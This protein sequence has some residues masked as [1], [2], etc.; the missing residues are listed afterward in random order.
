MEQAS[1]G[2]GGCAREANHLVPG[3]R[4]MLRQGHPNKATGAHDQKT[5]APLLPRRMDVVSGP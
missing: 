3:A 2:L 5:H 1:E 4:Q